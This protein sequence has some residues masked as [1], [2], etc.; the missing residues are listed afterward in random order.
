MHKGLLAVLCAKLW[1]GPALQSL[2]PGRY[3]DFQR[4]LMHSLA[5]TYMCKPVQLNNSAQDESHV[6]RFRDND[7]LKYS[8]RGLEMYAPWIRNVY[9]V[10]NGQ[11]CNPCHTK[12]ATSRGCLAVLCKRVDT[13]LREQL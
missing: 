13:R 2:H 7:E 3:Y 9:I 1:K 6:R 8:L 5:A 10:T 11:V 4:L 12:I